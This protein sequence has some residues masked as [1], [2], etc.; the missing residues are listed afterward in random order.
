MDR[1][2]FTRR[3]PLGR[4]RRRVVRDDQARDVA[5]R[6]GDAM[7]AV[8]GVTNLRGVAGHLHVLRR[9]VLEQGDEVD[10]LLVV[11][12]ESH[13]RLLPD[14]C[15][16]RLMVE[17]CVVEPVQEMDRARARRGEAHADLARPL[18][19]C[20][21][22]ERRHL[23]VT[24]L[25]ELQLVLV[26]LERADDRVD[27]VARITVDPPHAVLGEP[28]EE[29]VS[30]QLSHRVLLT[31][32]DPPQTRRQAA[33]SAVQNAHLLAATGI[34][35]RHSGHWRTV[36]STGGSVRRLAIS[37][38]TGLT[39]RKKT[40]TAITRNVMRALM[41]APYR[42]W[43]LLI[44][45]LSVAKFGLPPIA[46]SS[47]VIRSPTRAVTTAANAT[48]ITMPTAMST[49]LP[50]SKNSLKSFTARPFRPLDAPSVAPSRSWT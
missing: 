45:K 8:D 20:A 11:A 41:K 2:V 40:T 3:V 4:L 31:A 6:E 42:K 21:R 49:R 34:S 22:H 7:R 15:H 10:L 46:A 18:R 12:A 27:P 35:L 44:V 47:G 24:H 33:S 1:A 32:S 5:L 43:L 28:F 36:S 14:D 50:R 17:L 26:A 48:P 25:H 38:L 39:T 30:S 29:K 23:L 13:A 19:V 37:A 16:H 9:D